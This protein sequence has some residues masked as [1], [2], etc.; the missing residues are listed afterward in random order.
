MRKKRKNMEMEEET[1]GRKTFILSLVLL[2]LL[3]ICVYVCIDTQMYTVYIF[4]LSIFISFLL[5]KKYCI[6]Y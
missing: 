5:V 2:V 4:F 1:N 3:Y 6:Y